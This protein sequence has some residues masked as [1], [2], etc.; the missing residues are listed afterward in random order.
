MALDA[1]P[2][3]AKS[4]S[5]LARTFKRIRKVLTPTAKK[6]LDKSELRTKDER[7]AAEAV[8]EIE[9]R[10]GKTIKRKL[11]EGCKILGTFQLRWL[12]DGEV[13]QLNRYEMRCLRP[14][15]A[16]T[17][18]KILKKLQLWG[19]RQ[20]YRGKLVTGTRP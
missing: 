4:G 13:D 18:Q 1:G 9:G 20:W 15:M 11:L 19:P 16:N 12:V 7:R 3:T 5:R 14:A 6:A 17:P 2:S 10:K 8:L